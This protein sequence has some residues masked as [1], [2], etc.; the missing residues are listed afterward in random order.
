MALGFNY[1]RI[2]NHRRSDYDIFC[3]SL[4]IEGNPIAKTTKAKYECVT[5]GLGMSH[6]H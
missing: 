5:N 4:H 1:C 6:L 3:Q 2:A